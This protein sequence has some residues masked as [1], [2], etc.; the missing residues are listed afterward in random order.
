MSDFPQHSLRGAALYNPHLH[1][2]NEL[3]SLFV[4]RQDLLQLLLEDLRATASGQTA[5]HHLILGQRGMGKTMLLRRLG[6]AIEEDPVLGRNWLPLSFPEEQYN[7]ARLS[8]FWLN[9]TDALSDLLETRG[10]HAEAERL[11]EEA[12][13]LR[14]FEEDRRAREALALLVGAA[15]RIE[16]RLVLLVDNVDLVFD[17][18]KEQEWALREVLSSEPALVLIGAS[19]NAVESSFTYSQAFYDFFRV[20]EL[21]GLSLEET[22]QL[23]VHYAGI[24]GA[25]EVKRVAEQESARIKVLH[26][27]TGGNPRTIV[28]L[29]NVLASGVDGDV[30]SDIERLLD[31]CTPL[32]KARFEALAAQAQQVVHAMAVH[33]D[34]ISAGELAE[35][36]GLEVNAVSSQL[37]RLVKQGVVEKV[38]YDPESRTGFQIAERFFNIWYLMRASRRVRRRL[39][40]LVEFLRM[41]YSQDQLRAKALDH[42]QSGLDLNPALRLRYAEY[43]FA[44]A[45]AIRDP[46][47]SNSLERSGLQA[48]LHDDVLRNQLAELIDLDESEP[49]LKEKAQLDLRLQQARERVVSAK[50]DLPEWS[51][52]E[53]WTKLN[54]SLLT[55]LEVKVAIAEKLSSLDVERISGI[56]HQLDTEKRALEDLYACSRTVES[57]IS[58]VRSGLMTGP[59]DVEG[60]TRVEAV[61]GTSGLRAIALA[62]SLNLQFKNEVLSSLEEVLD[63][64]D[65]P[66]PWLV[67]LH[68]ASASEAP[69]FQKLERAI[70]RISELTPDR[71]DFTMVVAESLLRL[72]RFS[73]AESILRDALVLNPE[74][75]DAWTGL[76][77]AQAE[78]GNLDLAED[79]LKKALS[80]EPEDWI[81]W[82]NLCAVLVRLERYEEAEEIASKAIELGAGATTWNRLASIQVLE[83]QEDVAEKT[84]RDAISIHNATSSLWATLG[85]ILWR[86]GS[87]SEAEKAF[88]TSLAIDPDEPR[89]K[90]QAAWFFLSF[91]EDF[92][93]AA[94]LVRDL[95]GQLGDSDA[96][97]AAV[98]VHKGD[99]EEA[100][101]YAR[102][103]IARQVELDWDRTLTFFRE[104]VRKGKAREA[105][106]LLLETGAAE[107]WRPL[108]E[109]LEAVARGSKTYLRRVAPEVRQPAR[110]ILEEL[111]APSRNQHEPPDPSKQNRRKRKAPQRQ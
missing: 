49:D 83:G 31:Q 40:W 26:N 38:E 12:E 13:A 104:A 3:I 7:I 67:W 15:K 34:P 79:S 32:Y 24:W 80:I 1:E 36:L 54:E 96:I 65:S 107:R 35:V 81:T 59:F 111:L 5:Q 33:W 11:D 105:I 27:L 50:V 82:D 57:L 17:R 23:L 91:E 20:H 87:R 62:H 58:A 8:D 110:E 71:V 68:H 93:S 66:F 101:R 48:I 52:E 78:M 86:R 22:R 106:E 73:R 25:P 21:E 41:F 10:Q 100:V 45:S 37:S 61:L 109:A 103:Y 4:V 89:V 30:R 43:S 69:D 97:R 72:K 92:D 16:R 6:F 60:A 47:W 51:G 70:A 85:L 88:R 64:T 102:G 84:I 108:R 99:W 9:C 53:F 56:K 39:L 63:T 19:S 46:T 90:S 14:R 74:N 44:L 95:P 55:P 75:A 28:L 42:I 18:I 2:K 29:F 76:G 94:A 77:L 98:L